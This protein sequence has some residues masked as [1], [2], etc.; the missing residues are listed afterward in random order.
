MDAGVAWELAEHRRRTISDLRYHFDLRISEEPM[1]PIPATGLIRFRWNDPDGQPLVVDFVAPDRVASVRVNDQEVAFESVNDHLVIPSEALVSD[2]ENSLALQFTA[3][4]GSLNRND[5]FLY[6]LFVPDRARF[7]LPVFDQPNLKGRFAVTLTVPPG[8]TAVA[9]GPLLEEVEGDGDGDPAS[10][11]VFRFAESRPLPS[12]L[13]AFAAGR[14]QVERATRDGREMR[15][16]HRETDREK[17]ERNLEAVFDLHA[18]ALAWLEEYTG[19]EYPFQKFDWVAIPSFQ[20][21]GMEHAGSILYRSDRLF[22]EESATQAQYLARASVIAHETAHMWFGDL[23]TMDW[24]DDVWMKEVFANFMAAKIIRPSFPDVDHDLRF[25]SHHQSAYEIDRTAGANPIRQPLENLREAGTLYGPIIYQKAPVVM[26]LLEQM[27]GEETFREAMRHYLSAF[28]YDNATWLDLVEILDLLSPEDVAAWSRVWVEDAGRPTVQAR[29]ET[30]AAGAV[31]RLVATQ[32][33]PL[34]RERL[35]PQSLTVAL[36][37][38]TGTETVS[39]RLFEGEGVATE[40]RGGPGPDFLLPESEA[41]GYARFRLDEASRAYLLARLSELQDPLVRGVAWLTLWDALL[42]GEVPPAPF[43]DQLLQGVASESDELN[44]QRILGFL[45]TLYWRFLKEED[46]ARRA[47]EVEAA[48]WERL[49]GS[50]ET[51]TRAML[52]QTYRDVALSE[53]AV[54]RLRRVWEGMEQVPGVPM[55]EE[56]LTTLAYELAV[57]DVQGWGDV[58]EAQME[59]I[60]NPDRRD[61]FSFVRPVLSDDP[62]AR[63]AWFDRLRDAANRER[64]PWVLEGLRYLHHPLRAADA[65]RYILPSLELVEE[66][67]RT[68]DI[69]FPARWLDATLGGH[70]SP[71]AVKTVR[72]FLEARPDYP[73]RLRAKILQ[74]ADMVLRASEIT[75]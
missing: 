70:G 28:S 39:L 66:I 63:A 19:I 29:V 42:E 7:A 46:R 48:I 4:D 16:F 58:L 10:V 37:Y 31:T 56:D 32:E 6:T 25:L 11:R 67:Q 45:E 73:P 43:L 36:G 72:S 24:F 65:E 1:A 60:E 13:F 51:T 53:G 2:G 61:R 68:G 5:E 49:G 21:G 52:F 34:G 33:D 57:R 9:N 64:E 41:V 26:Q 55:S 3:G 14:F 23:V 22:L 27:V 15:F 74:S 69:F 47:L 44:L 12:Y 59:R 20:F 54:E 62:A 17:V 38:G 30:D 75:G 8:W 35:W 50:T 71:A 40:V 18:A